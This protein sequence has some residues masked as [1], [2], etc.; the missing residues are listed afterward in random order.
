MSFFQKKKRSLFLFVSLFPF[1]LSGSILSSHQFY[2]IFLMIYFVFGELSGLL[3]PRKWEILEILIFLELTVFLSHFS[4]SLSFPGSLNSCAIGH[5]KKVPSCSIYLS[6]FL[7]GWF[8]DCSWSARLTFVMHWVDLLFPCL[9]L[10]GFTVEA[11]ALCQE[12][13]TRSKSSTHSLVQVDKESSLLVLLFLLFLCASPTHR[14]RATQIPSLSH[15]STHH[16][17]RARHLAWLNLQC[18]VPYIA[19]VWDLALPC[20]CFCCYELCLE[21]FLSNEVVIAI[22]DSL[23]KG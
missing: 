7:F 17:Q 1:S 16:L 3:F 8:L 22:I 4:L 6:P 11:Q 10:Q 12:Q 20:L 14:C 21:I 15:T 19:I 13:D 2:S 5:T 18:C 9:W 23:C